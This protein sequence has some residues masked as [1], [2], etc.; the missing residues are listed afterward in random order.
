M[1]PFTRARLTRRWITLVALAIQYVAGLE[2]YAYPKA[3][4]ETH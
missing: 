1:T 2:G 3:S 4:T